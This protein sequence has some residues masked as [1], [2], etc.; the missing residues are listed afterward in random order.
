MF[1]TLSGLIVRLVA[2]ANQGPK[3]KP[4]VGEFATFLTA[5]GLRRFASLRD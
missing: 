2:P 5:Y 4:T 3:A 1:T